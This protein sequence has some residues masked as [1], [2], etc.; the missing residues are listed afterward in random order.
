MKGF[1]KNFNTVAY[2]FD[3]IGTNRILMT[4]VT[5][6]I[7]FRELSNL[8][9][10][11]RYYIS[12][13]ATPDSVAFELYGDS[14]SHWLLYLVNPELI[15]GWPLNYNEME[16]HI[17]TLYGNKSFLCGA[18]EQIMLLPSIP[19]D[20]KIHVKR[21]DEYEQL[22]SS[23]LYFDASRRALICESSIEISN[24]IENLGKVYL[25]SATANWPDELLTDDYFE[26]S[27]G[28]NS[29]IFLKNAIYSFGD[30]GYRESLI[31]FEQSGVLPLNSISFEQ[32][33]ISDNE[34]KRYIRVFNAES[35]RLVAE[36]YKR[37]LNNAS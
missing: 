14:Y 5:R 30:K 24:Q 4:D 25:S 31:E 19:D 18:D 11:S 2:Q 12:D 27:L 22:D 34:Q 10:Y 9:Q 15:N 36:R 8:L 1:F 28:K 35:A 6:S 3:S 17:E 26:F 33:T 23:I 37:L 29:T 16:K 21:E 20:I 7:I 13:L 32:K